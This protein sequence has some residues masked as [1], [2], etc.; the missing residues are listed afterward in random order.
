MNSGDL[1]SLQC[2]VHKGDL[3]INITWLHNNKTIGY[4]DGILVS[5]AGKKVSTITIDSVQAQH[6][7][8][9]TCKVGNR[10]GVSQYSTNLHVNG[11]KFVFFLV[12]VF[13]SPIFLFLSHLFQWYPKFYRLVSVK[14]L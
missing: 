5:K 7:G 14:I 13:Y 8:S 6:A 4:E 9:Y 2:A 10:A 1:A 11:I 12:F 3:P